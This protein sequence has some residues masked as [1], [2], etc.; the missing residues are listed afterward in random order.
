MRLIPLVPQ[1]I[2]TLR[3]LV[4]H[5]DRIV[6]AWG[7]TPLNSTAHSAGVWICSLEK[8]HCLGLTKGGQPKHP[9][10]LRKGTPLMPLRG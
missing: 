2:K 10:R 6:A 5:A 8:T 9:L 1:N 4:R 7:A 3:R